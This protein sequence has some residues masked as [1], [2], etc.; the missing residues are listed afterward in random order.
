M[1]IGNNSM[2]YTGSYSQYRNTSKD[3]IQSGNLTDFLGAEKTSLTNYLKTLSE[4]YQYNNAGTGDGTWQG[5]F[6]PHPDSTPE[7]PIVIAKGT[8]NGVDFDMT[9]V[10]NEVNPRNASHIEMMACHPYMGDSPETAL[11]AIS[12]VIFAASPSNG[13]EKI[14]FVSYSEQFAKRSPSDFTKSNLDIFMNHLE[15]YEKIQKEQS[16]DVDVQ[17]LT[18]RLAEEEFSRNFHQSSYVDTTET[19]SR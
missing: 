8:A 12:E 18:Q 17:T 3:N 4:S 6:Y 19:V 2:S 16:T 11:A 9:I 5:C 10:V 15:K 13:L 14:D 1:N 7:N